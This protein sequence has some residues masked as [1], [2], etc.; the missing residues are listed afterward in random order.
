MVG[1]QELHDTLPRFVDEG[2]VGLDHHPWLYRPCAGC[3][4]FGSP[5]HLH[6]THAAVS[7]YH[8]LLMIAVSR[9]GTSG[10]LARLDEGRAGW[11]GR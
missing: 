1:E 10:F 5:L 2:R 8:Q 6:Q 11:E 7:G 9:D 3:H 4:R